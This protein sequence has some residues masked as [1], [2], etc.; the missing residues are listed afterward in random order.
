MSFVRPI[1]GPVP[2]NIKTR[3]RAQLREADRGS[4]TDD[5]LYQIL[6]FASSE[7]G[8][9]IDEF[10]GTIVDELDYFLGAG[11]Y[12][13]VFAFEPDGAGVAFKLKYGLSNHVAWSG[14][15]GALPGLIGKTCA[16]FCAV[17][18]G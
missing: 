6:Q 5:L 17:F 1:T 13:L 7:H 18:W 2:E 9:S 14:E 11:K 8:A 15:A 3:T 16:I 12:H 10:Y 4:L